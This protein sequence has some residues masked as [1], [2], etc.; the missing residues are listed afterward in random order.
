MNDSS[1]SFFNAF[2]DT[3]FE[4]KLEIVLSSPTDLP[5]CLSGKDYENHFIVFPIDNNPI[6]LQECNNTQSG[7]DLVFTPLTNNTTKIFLDEYFEMIYS[8]N[9]A[10]SISELSHVKLI[11]QPGGNCGYCKSIL[12]KAEQVQYNDSNILD[13][14]IQNESSDHVHLILPNAD[15]SNIFEHNVEKIIN[16][17]PQDVAIDIMYK[18]FMLQKKLK[19]QKDIL[20]IPD[21]LKYSIIKPNN[22]K[23]FDIKVIP[24]FT[25]SKDHDFIKEF[26]ESIEDIWGTNDNGEPLMFAELLNVTSIE[27]A[28]HVL[29]QMKKDFE[30]GL[31]PIYNYTD[32]DV[33]KNLNKEMV[34]WKQTRDKQQLKKI[35]WA[36]MLYSHIFDEFLN[37]ASRKHTISKSLVEN[38]FDKLFPDPTNWTEH[39]VSKFPEGHKFCNFSSSPF[40][41]IRNAMMQT[42]MNR[43]STILFVL[44]RIL[45]NSKN[46]LIL[47]KP[48]KVYRGTAINDNN[49]S[50]Q[51]QSL[52]VYGFVSTST[53]IDVPLHS[54]LKEENKV[55]FEITLPPGTRLLPIGICSKYTEDELLIISQGYAKVHTKSTIDT[56]FG[57]RRHFISTFSITNDIPDQ[58]TFKLTNS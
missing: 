37:S 30:K 21:A 24:L 8:Q 49:F 25:V 12:A 4:K 55:L 19:N 47:K 29:A 31:I 26:I 23:Y 6:V 48:I 40:K 10:K 33:E 34:Q 50:Q 16:T 52:K 58:P 5:I 32:T 39:M 41:P 1:Q 13:L 56:P 45:T 7:V 9:W 36:S 15:L 35:A 11:K 38:K 53:N 14:I 2:I 3:H 57:V 22:D 46:V 54:F 42:F 18:F 20:L 17:Y 43:V 51:T 27:N 44:H 28:I